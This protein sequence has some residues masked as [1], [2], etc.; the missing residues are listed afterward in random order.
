MRRVLI[1]VA[2]L[3]LATAIPASA[4]QSGSSQTP[5]G[6]QSQASKSTSNQP[7]AMTQQKVRE[8]LQ[9][10]GFSDLTI[11][12]AAYLVHA[13][14]ADGDPVVMFIDP[15]NMNTGS[16]QSGNTGASGTS[17]Q[18][19][20][21]KL[22]NNLQQAGFKDVMIVDAAYVVRGKSSDGSQVQMVINPPSN[23]TGSASGSSGS[24]SGSGSQSQSK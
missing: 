24:T 4:Q 14:T 16:A 6:A 15:P 7:Q 10:A 22:K 21:A 3:G 2:A 13:K 18:G 11:V 20:Q 12:D 17:A 1:T 5:S 19:P 9:K 8:N 23:T